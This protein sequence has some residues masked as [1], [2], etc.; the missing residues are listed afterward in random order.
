MR[1]LLDRLL[2]SICVLRQGHNLESNQESKRDPSD[3][4]TPMSLMFNC[5]DWKCQYVVMFC[6]HFNDG[7]SI[8][9]SYSIM[10]T[11]SSAS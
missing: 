1:Q 8:I 3:L 4:H 9:V 5:I 7:K 10:S 11:L 6:Y 2:L